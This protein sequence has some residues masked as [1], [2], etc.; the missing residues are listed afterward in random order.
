[1]REN[2]MSGEQDQ[3]QMQGFHL[4]QN[5]R[6]SAQLWGPSG[7]G[8]DGGG[9]VTAVIIGSSRRARGS[10][11]HTRR[12]HC[13][14]VCT[15][16]PRTAPAGAR[17]AVRASAPRQ[18]KRSLS[19]PGARAGLGEGARLGAPAEPRQKSPHSAAGVSAES[20]PATASPGP[21]Q[22]P[23]DLSPS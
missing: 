17:T 14:G 4:L 6:L 7:A 3:I 13:P 8:M 12:P 19:E 2:T 11:D 16:E 10:S 21:Q 20:P 22:H 5:T 15:P 1:M 23:R 18:G 9:L